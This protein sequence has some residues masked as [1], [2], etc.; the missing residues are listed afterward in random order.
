LIV[1]DTVSMFSA[2]MELSFDSR[3]LARVAF[4]TVTGQRGIGFYR[5]NLTLEF[6][7][8]APKEDGV[9]L[10]ALG[11]NLFVQ[12]QPLGRL[13]PLG[14]PVLRAVDNT[15]YPRDETLSVELTWAQVDALEA[16]RNGEG[17]NFELH[18][19]GR[20]QSATGLH[21][22]YASN[23]GIRVRQSEW[24]EVLH[25]MGF[26]QTMLIEVP[27]TRESGPVA[28]HLAAAQKASAVGHY[29]DAVG[30]CRDVME[31]QST[32]SGD[33]D[34][35]DSAVQALFANSRQMD[36][37]ARLKV[38]RRAFKLMTHPAR[39]ADEVAARFDWDREDA[40]CAVSIASALL[41]WMK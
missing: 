12:S 16:I 15:L 4:K 14:E 24:L 2:K 7:F 25:Q 8:L 5:L 6:T 10:V 40:I 20:V 27:I 17:L 39:H 13:L 35:T 1:R 29:R 41:R 33:G 31:A 21:N 26:Q 28:S 23:E 34:D 9:T 22:A 19:W 37:A 18:L 3:R 32:A 30:S 38:L 11:G 36:K